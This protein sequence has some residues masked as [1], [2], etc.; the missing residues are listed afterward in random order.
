M[1]YHRLYSH[2]AYEAS[3]PLRVLLT[4]MGTLGFQGS[5]KWWVL[6]HR[7]H[8][9][10]T[11]TNDDPYDAKKGLWFSH[12]GWI[13]E[14]P[15]YPKLKLVDASDLMADPVVVFQH[16]Y[17]PFLALTSCLLLPTLIGALWN[18]PVGGY[19]YGGIVTRLM[20]WHST[21]CINSLAHWMGDQ[22]FSK[23]TTARGGFILAL[24]TVGEGY[25]NFHHEFPTDYRN[26]IAWNDFD[27]TKWCIWAASQLGL[28]SNLR[29]YSDKEIQKGAVSQPLL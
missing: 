19:L 11:D 5:I 10:Y 27:P 25:H 22:K 20:V 2:R 4:F 29:I 21:F 6:R 26:G 3:L 15:F 9:R 24:F 13:F 23:E 1:G 28:A 12:M 17:Y 18:D 14:K 16:R 7:L 8:H